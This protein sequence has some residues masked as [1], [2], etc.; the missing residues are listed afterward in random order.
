MAKYMRLSRTQV[1]AEMSKDNLPTARCHSGETVIFEARNAY[2]DEFAPDG[3]PVPGD[4]TVNPATGPLFVEEARPGDVLR[5]DIIGID[6]GPVAFMRTNP[7]AGAFDNITGKIVTAYDVTG[8]SVQ[9]NDRVRLPLRPMIGVI[10]TAPAGAGISSFAPGPHGGNMDCKEIVEGSSLY[11]PVTVPGALLAMGDLHAL[12]G[13]GESMICGLEVDGDI[14]VRV[15]VL[16]GY[17]LPT[18]CLRSSGRFAAIYS[19][20][21]LDE[22]AV[23]AARAMQGFLMAHGGL[24][25]NDSS[26][27]VSLVGDLA[28]C[29]IVDP[30]MTVRM[31]VDLSVLEQLGV[32]LP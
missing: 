30:L 29:Q 12:M 17:A 22:A 25:V 10:G 5:V 11:L 2:N 14:T 27:L 4:G 1:I 23:M 13:D 21:T 24:D 16:K 3:S 28:I 20:L 19:A 18:P 6:L 26:R 7:E 8:T 31:S 15:T 9:F 32:T